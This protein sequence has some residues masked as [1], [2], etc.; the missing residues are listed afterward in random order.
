MVPKSSMEILDLCDD[1]IDSDG[2]QKLPHNLKIFGR[3]KTR[4]RSMEVQP[5]KITKTVIING[6]FIDRE[7]KQNNLKLQKMRSIKYTGSTRSFRAE[8]ILRKDSTGFLKN[9]SELRRA[10]PPFYHYKNRNKPYMDFLQ[11]SMHT[12]SQNDSALSP[13]D[14]E[15]SPEVTS[16][17][18]IAFE[19]YLRSTGKYKTQLQNIKTRKALNKVFNSKNYDD[20]LGEMQI[21]LQKKEDINVLLEKA[22]KAGMAS[23]ENHTDTAFAKVKTELYD[24]DRFIEKNSHGLKPAETIQFIGG[25]GFDQREIIEKENIEIEE[26]LKNLK[27]TLKESTQKGRKR[28][29]N[30]SST[31]LDTNPTLKLDSPNKKAKISKRNTL[32]NPP[33][34]S[35]LRPVS[36][37]S[38]SNSLFPKINPLKILKEETKSEVNKNL[39]LV[40]PQ[41]LPSTNHAL[42][43]IQ[44][45]FRKKYKFA[46]PHRASQSLLALKPLFH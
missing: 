16:P 11:S 8:E 29:R 4:R 9:F 28:G 36:P 19:N 43:Q 15:H 40:S 3:K 25:N 13:D 37:T 46:K 7:E 27:N 14:N 18:Q 44:K 35:I 45:K 21:I 1:A 17:K 12:I 5:K 26:M 41:N 24:L 34:P 31:A 30:L 39:C 20:I 38:S 23:L 42:L 32:I 33:T 22:R 2:H 6:P 10:I